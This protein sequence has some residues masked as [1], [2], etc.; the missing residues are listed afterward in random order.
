MSKAR[1]MPNV[2]PRCRTARV[3]RAALRLHGF[4]VHLERGNRQRRA[5]Q[6]GEPRA[7]AGVRAAHRQTQECVRPKAVQ[8]ILPGQLA[9][10]AGNTPPHGSNVVVVRGGAV[11]VLL[12]VVVVGAWVVV[13]IATTVVVVVVAPG[14]VVVGQGF[15]EQLPG[16]ALSPSWALHCVAVLTSM[17]VSKAP[18]GDDRTQHW[19]QGFGEQLPGP[20]LSP[21]WALH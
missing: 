4:P 20:A 3:A 19:V 14:A 6:R 13:V 15:G 7:A 5:G 21:S 12:E 10:Q 1:S 18:P 16:P 2:P 8:R 9:R 11:V 17:Q